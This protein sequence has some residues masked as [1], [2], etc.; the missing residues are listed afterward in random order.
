MYAGT[1][2]PPAYWSVAIL[3]LW[4]YGIIVIANKEI[5]APY[6]DWEGNDIMCQ[7]VG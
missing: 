2:S 3:V 4:I 6:K 1:K 7:L 5:K